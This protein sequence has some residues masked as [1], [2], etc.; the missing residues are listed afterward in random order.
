[1]FILSLSNQLTNTFN[2]QIF[3]KVL[4]FYK[5]SKVETM[6][7]KSKQ[8]FQIATYYFLRYLPVQLP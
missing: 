5:L 4:L 2:L 3:F 7:H 6:H 1:M 8:L